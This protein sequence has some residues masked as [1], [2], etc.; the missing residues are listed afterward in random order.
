MYCASEQEE[1]PVEES[2]PE[3]PE[4]RYEAMVGLEG[5]EDYIAY[6][7]CWTIFLLLAPW[8]WVWEVIQ[9]RTTY[10]IRRLR[11]TAPMV[12]FRRSMGRPVVPPAVRAGSEFSPTP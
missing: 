6:A 9:E 7:V 1:E 12:A 3:T 11:Q 5:V 8:L 2:R 4:P 10:L